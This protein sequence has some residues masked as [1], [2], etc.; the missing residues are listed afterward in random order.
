MTME[1]LIMLEHVRPLIE[2]AEQTAKDG[3]VNEALR[4]LRKLCLMDFGEFFLELPNQQFPHLSRLL[5]RMA[6]E[7]VQVAWTGASGR[8]LLTGTVDFVRM[9]A[10]HF[11]QYC[12]RPLQD[13]RMLDFG[14]GYGR[15][16][17]VM[18]WYTYPDEYFGV[19]PWDRSLELC[20]QDGLLGHF[21]PSDYVPETLPVGD[22]RFDLI[23]AFS[24]FTHTSERVTRSALRTLRKYIRN[25]G[26]LVIT[27]R[28]VEYCTILQRLTPEQ[29][30]QQISQYRDVGFSF[31]PIDYPKLGDELIFGDTTIDPQWIAAAFPEWEL[32]GYDRGLDVWQTLLFLTPR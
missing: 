19:D 6:A 9:V 13:A 5:P 31:S 28:P 21:L 16:A 26:L 29:R 3:H 15:V 1:E 30:A 27:V 14:C 8:H 11:Q 22:L 2:S 18:Y 25:N 23:F 12:S 32:R 10:S 4:Q 20:R 17:R 7:D 24:V